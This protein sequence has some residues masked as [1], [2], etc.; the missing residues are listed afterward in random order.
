MK[1]AEKRPRER[2]TAPHRAGTVALIGRTNVGKSTLLN[3]L[4]GEKISIV[5]DVP[6]TTRH[7]IQGVLTLP[8][9]QIVFVDT[10]GFHKPR[11]R[12]NRVMVDAAREAIR[13]VDLVVFM[14][15]AADGIGPGDLY[16]GRLL[17]SVEGGRQVP[18]IAVLNKID[19]LEKKKL[20]PLL[21]ECA[22]HW[23][24]LEFVPLSAKDG[25]N[26]DRLRDL[27][28]ARLPE[29]PPLH[30]GDTLTDQPARIVVSEFI[31]EQIL[32]RTR[33]E[34]PHATAVLVERWRERDDGVTEIDAVIL[35][36]RESQ[37]GILIGHGGAFL[38]QVGTEARL[39][40][41]ALLGGKIM[42]S[43][44]VKVR[45]GWRDDPRSL[46]DMGIE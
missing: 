32:N 43:L 12:M 31:R 10:P 3:R 5:A 17:S 6:Q 45:E 27:I 40:A 22:R 14:I 38:K 39:A 30:P 24:F 33:Q 21:E 13:E 29:A 16:I 25:E 36:E 1:A 42:L 23:K 15:D 8:G 26:C 4:I 44:F 20:L 18:V 19:R 9:A 41:E 2:R 37:K 46:E 11:H 34:L 28:V 7:R 35:C